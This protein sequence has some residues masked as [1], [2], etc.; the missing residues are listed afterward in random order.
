MEN[1]SVIVMPDDQMDY[2]DA[3]CYLVDDISQLMMLSSGCC[4][5]VDDVIQLML[6]SS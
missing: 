4:Y 5:P 3:S 2:I 6:L 1:Q